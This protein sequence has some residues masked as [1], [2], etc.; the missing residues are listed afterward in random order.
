[1]LRLFPDLTG[2]LAR[3]RRRCAWGWLLA[4]LL[5]VG[6]RAPLVGADEAV[7]F[8]RVA[9]LFQKHCYGCHG[10]EKAK[11]KLR[12]DKLNPDLVNGKDGDHWREIHDRLNFGD[13]PPATE[14]A[15]KK[16]D[17]ELMTAWLA[18][19]R[20]R[21]ALAKNQATHFRRLTRYE[22]ERTMQD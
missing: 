12:I 8:A 17:R 10:S 16:E 7:P 14:P 11:G 22:Y 3:H 5:L 6:G 21:A 18:Q 19:E 15:L 20:R 13:M 9:P 4:I 2:G 1:M